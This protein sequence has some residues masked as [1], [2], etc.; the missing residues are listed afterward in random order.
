M[1]KAPSDLPE[2]PMLVD[3]EQPLAPVV[4]IRTETTLSRYPIHRIAKKADVKIKQTVRN[5][6]GKLITN[7][8]V[9]HPPGPLAY[10]L[11][12]LIINRRIDE[13]R[14]GGEIKQL[15]KVGSLS[16]I[17]RELGFSDSGKNRNAIKESL[18]EN[19]GALITA[20]INYKSTDGTE[21]EFEFTTTRYTVI[22]TGE[23]LPNNKK[24]DSV[25]IEL[26]PRYHEMLRHS[27]TRP[28][29]YKYLRELPPS[30]QRLYELLSFTMYGTLKHGRPN[31]QTL[32]SEFCKSAPLTR[33][34]EWDKVRPQ[35]WKIH[36]PHID[37]GYIKSVEFEETLNSQGVIDWVIKYTPGRKAKHEFKEF[38]KKGIAPGKTRLIAAIDPERLLSASRDA[39]DR[40][41]HLLIEKLVAAG[42]NDETARM[43][44]E[45]YAAAAERELA[46]WPTRDKSGMKNPL[47]WLR[48]A[49]ESGDFAQPPT[50]V[51]ARAPRKKTKESAAKKTREDKYNE[52]YLRKYVQ[53]FAAKLPAIDAEAFKTYQERCERIDNDGADL[54]EEAREFFK[55]WELAEMAQYWPEIKFLKFD[56]WLQKEHPEAYAG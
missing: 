29:D 46:A 6:Q 37:A 53:P 34:V 5:A 23:K 56:D 21:R 42:F 15:F 17:C 51:E 55:L 10:K 4:P 28:L 27:R 50:L 43:L 3:E 24:A 25:Y 26:H 30:A 41:H 20:R 54:P 7:W 49:I 38:S 39:D 31:V 1:R 32:Y 16:E 22:F 47:G 14:N 33:Y 12:T 19:A 13:M 48:K 40:V 18:K 35:M 8:E 9:K 44:A 45:K 2:I 36:K 52:T 11:D